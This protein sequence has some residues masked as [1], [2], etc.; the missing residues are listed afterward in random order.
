MKD[1]IE[2]FIKYIIKLYTRPGPDVPQPTL[3]ADGL[4]SPVTTSGQHVPLPQ[5]S[6][7][8][9]VQASRIRAN[10]LLLLRH[11][12]TAGDTFECS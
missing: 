3:S 1:L 11:V 8:Y 9:A 2:D 12:D 7:R 4:P 6:S 5:Q 10:L